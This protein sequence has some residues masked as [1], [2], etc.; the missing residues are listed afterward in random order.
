MRIT[1]SM[2][3]NQ[4][5]V[6][7]NRNMTKINGLYMQQSTGKRVN[8]P[9][10]DPISASRILALR[11]NISEVEQ[12]KKNVDQAS[13][14]MEVTEQAYSNTLD[15]LTRVRELSVEGSSDTLSIEDRKKIATDINSLVEQLGIEMNASYAGRYVFSGYRTD[16]EPVFTK[17]DPTASYNITQTFSADDLINKD[18]YQKFGNSDLGQITNC[19]TISLG[20]NDVENVSITYVDGTGTTQ[21][22]TPVSKNIADTDAYT[23]ASGEVYYIEETGE[24]IIGSDVKDIIKDYDISVNYDKTG[25]VVGDLN[26]KVYF[27]CTD[28]NTGVSYDMIGQDQIEYE[29]SVGNRISVNSLA[30]DVL[31]D[32]IYGQLTDFTENILSMNKS[33][34]ASLRLKYEAEGY[35]GEAL[36]EKIDS[37]LQQEESLMSAAAQDAFSDLI[38]ICDNSISSISVQHTDLGSRMNRVDLIRTRLEGQE[39]SYTDLLSE[40][41]DADFVQVIMDLTSA[42]AIY[43]ASLKT[44]TSVIQT[45]LVDF[46]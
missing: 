46:I 27:D 37:Q 20:Y 11:S 24:L 38:K 31:T 14:W 33:T 5:M 9:S 16:E 23:P 43:Q 6:N 30:K 10:D 22:I 32:N 4:M 12:Y 8:V 26:P 25:F 28:K 41:E 44:G 21:T 3:Q 34:E 17:N 29:V 42:E 39:M 35:T 40:T 19:D 18:I 36:Q 2:I 13:S 45:S 7:V 15:I 1:N